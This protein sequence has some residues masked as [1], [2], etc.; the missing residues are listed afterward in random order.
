MFLCVHYWSCL[1][2]DKKKNRKNVIHIYDVY[3]YIYMFALCRYSKMRKPA[4]LVPALP[5]TFIVAYIGD[6]AYG[7]KMT[8]IK[9]MHHS[10]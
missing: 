6:M 8:R 2:T 9:G 1:S 3:N 5:L 10:Q 7:S 4:I